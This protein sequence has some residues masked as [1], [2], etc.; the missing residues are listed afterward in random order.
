MAGRSSISRPA[1]P[2]PVKFVVAG[3]RRPGNGTE[4]CYNTVGQASDVDR[5]YSAART[6][7]FVDLDSRV[8]DYEDCEEVLRRTSSAC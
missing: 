5:K 7:P 3:L 4:I 6:C 2:F 1:G 8:Y